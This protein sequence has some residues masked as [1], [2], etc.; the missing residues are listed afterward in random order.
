M[1]LQRDHS[2]VEE[3]MRHLADADD[4]G[5]GLEMHMEVEETELA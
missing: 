1:N 3:V 5:N 4:L 2:S